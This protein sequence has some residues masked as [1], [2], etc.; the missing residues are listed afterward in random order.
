MQPSNLSSGLKTATGVILDRTCILVGVQII[1]DKTNDV[2]L[3]LHDNA[4]AAS[5]TINFKQLVPGTDDSLP[6]WFG[7]GGIRCVNGIYATLSG[8]AAEFIIFYR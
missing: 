5:G 7:D 1:T 2:S 8:T 4:S 3:I 6:Y